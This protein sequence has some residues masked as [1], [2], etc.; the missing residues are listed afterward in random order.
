MTEQQNQTCKEGVV[1]E[2]AWMGKAILIVGSVIVL[3]TAAAGGGFIMLRDHHPQSQSTMERRVDLLEQDM[4]RLEQRAARLEDVLAEVLA[5]QTATAAK[6]AEAR[7]ATEDL[8]VSVPVLPA[9]AASGR[10]VKRKPMTR[11]QAPQGSDYPQMERPYPWS[12]WENPPSAP[13]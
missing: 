3:S 2:A 11:H 6:A 4:G 12:A 9:P 7:S 1:T 8:P 13:Q 5:V 10:S